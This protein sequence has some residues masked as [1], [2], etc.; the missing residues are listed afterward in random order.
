MVYSGYF[1]RPYWKQNWPW[2]VAA[3]ILAIIGG[4]SIGIAIGDLL[5]KCR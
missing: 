4:L 5:F 1:S 2:I 3:E